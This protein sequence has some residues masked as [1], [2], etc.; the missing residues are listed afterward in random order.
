[1]CLA[2]RAN[3]VVSKDA[4]ISQVWSDTFVT[5]DSLVQCI[6]E[7]RRAIG[8]HDR[9]IVETL[10]KRGYRLNTKAGQ[11]VRDRVNEIPRVAVLAFRDLSAGEKKGLVSDEVA[12][13]LI[14]ELAHFGEF[15][16]VS[17]HASFQNTLANTGLAD[18]AAKLGCQYVVEGSQQVTANTFRVAIN[19]VDVVSQSSFWS[20]SFEV[21]WDAELDMQSDLVRTIAASV[22]YRIREH[23]PSLTKPDEQSAMLLFLASGADVQMPS[24]AAIEQSIRI[25]NQ[26]IEVDPLSPYGYIGLSF[27]H[28]ANYLD[29]WDVN[30]P[31]LSVRNAVALADKALELSP[32]NSQ[33]HFASGEAHL[34][35]NNLPQA[36]QR[37]RRSL[38]LNPHAPHVHASTACLNLFAGRNDIALQEIDQAIG[39][40]PLHPDWFL[41]L[42]S[43]I[44]RQMEEFQA[45]LGV[46]Q[47]MAT[48]PGSNY[49]NQAAIL[50][51]LGRHDEA[52]V[53][54]RKFLGKIPH[55]TVARE[56]EAVEGKFVRPEHRDAWLKLIR[57]AGLPD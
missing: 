55:H 17:Q 43:A 28:L 44:L 8:D 1:M 20:H 52:Q 32:R 18:I 57:E 39:L 35:A 42:K 9:T 46:F 24:K 10:V 2:S 27:S 34:A 48:V 13:G 23:A 29:R 22:G 19:L 45:A 50:A 33:A 4:I 47:K 49:M 31:N 12:A 5:D 6:K 41:A 38:E 14:T 30:D 7:I 21:D 56:R 11:N 40:D 37:F 15:S 3:E 16:V 51:G 26:A 53:S 25:N 36:E 54:M